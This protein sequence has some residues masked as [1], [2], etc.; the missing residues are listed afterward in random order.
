[1][2]PLEETPLHLSYSERK[3]K[4]RAENKLFRVFPPFSLS[5]PLLLSSP[6]LPPLPLSL[7]IRA[8]TGPGSSF[9]ACS[10]FLRRIHLYLNLSPDFSAR[11][12]RCVHSV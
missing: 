1:M 4:R 7:E 10:L 8:V 11:L 6:S 5:L 2:H 3:Y 9:N 12:I